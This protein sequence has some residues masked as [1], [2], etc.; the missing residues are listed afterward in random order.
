M[1][2]APSGVFQLTGTDQAGFVG[3]DHRLDPVAQAE[4]LEDVPTWVFTA[5]SRNSVPAT[6]ALDIPRATSRR[7]SASRSVRA[8]SRWVGKFPLDRL[9]AV[10]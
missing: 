9:G 5:L 10:D 6:S 8:S 1:A 7:T 4:L 2:T 3:K